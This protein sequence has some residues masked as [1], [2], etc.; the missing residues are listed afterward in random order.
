MAHEITNFQDKG[1]VYTMN[2]QENGT[3]TPMII[4]KIDAVIKHGPDGREFISHKPGEKY[5]ITLPN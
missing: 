4:P 2:C 3:T 5:F 1:S